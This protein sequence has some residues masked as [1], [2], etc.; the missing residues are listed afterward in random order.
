MS[1]IPT[2][3][4][5]TCRK[6]PTWYGNRQIRLDDYYIL[7]TRVQNADEITEIIRKLT[8]KCRL[9]RKI[10][11]PSK[12]EK[13]NVFLLHRLMAPK[14]RRNGQV[15]RKI[16]TSKICEGGEIT[17]PIDLRYA[18]GEKKKREFTASLKHGDLDLG[19]TL[20]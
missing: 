6:M 1:K 18:S 11:H 13:F 14:C 7:S 20:K 17:L 9:Y 15:F 12:K 10:F 5:N 4:P 19:T 2:K 8:G 16:P 3:W